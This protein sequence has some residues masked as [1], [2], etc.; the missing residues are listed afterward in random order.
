MKSNVTFSRA[1]A[2]FARDSQLR[3]LRVFHDSGFHILPRVRS[4]AMTINALTIPNA[5]PHPRPPFGRGQEHVLSMYPTIF[6]DAVS[7]RKLPK[8]STIL[9]LDPVRLKVMRS[10]GHD[11][12]SI[13]AGRIWFSFEWINR[14]CAARFAP[15]CERLLSPSGIDQIDPE[16]VTFSRQT[17]RL[18]AGLE[19]DIVDNLENPGQRLHVVAMNEPKPDLLQHE[20]QALVEGRADENGVFTAIPGGL[21]LKCPTRYEEMEPEA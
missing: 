8:F 7:P 6:Q 18:S 13:D 5:K 11:D 16:F 9:T 10:C 1:M 2:R 17:T 3:N 4:R 20:A 19:F 15:F 14:V 21:M 12:L